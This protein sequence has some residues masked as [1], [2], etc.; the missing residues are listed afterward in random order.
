MFAKS[1]ATSPDECMAD[2]GSQH[3]LKCNFIE[4]ILSSAVL[5]EEML[6]VGLSLLRRGDSER[7]SHPLLEYN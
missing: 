2:V 1:E 4:I 6:F 7:E 5:S 3:S